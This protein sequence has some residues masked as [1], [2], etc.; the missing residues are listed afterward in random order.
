MDVEDLGQHPLH[1]WASGGGLPA[2]GRE[3]AHQAG[4]PHGCKRHGT[5]MLSSI[6]DTVK[7][8]VSKDTMK[9]PMN[10]T[11]LD[12]GYKGCLF[13]KGDNVPGTMEED[14]LWLIETHFEL[15]HPAPPLV[16]LEGSVDKVSWETFFWW[17]VHY[18][19]EI[20]CERG[21]VYAD[22]LFSSLDTNLGDVGDLIWDKLGERYFKMTEFELIVEADK[23]AVAETMQ[24][25]GQDQL[26][27]KQEKRII[28][29]RKGIAA[30][31]LTV[32]QQQGTKGIDTVEYQQQQDNQN[33]GRLQCCRAVGHR[34]QAGAACC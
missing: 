10:N 28:K 9:V 19:D 34:G 6:K 27:R 32:E 33:S 25:P 3:D 31:K 16:I 21:K 12:C 5:V 7:I 2:V 13:R 24:H 8:P 30:N 14:H 15:E 4:E 23:I 17:Y 1:V 18:R 11:T 26:V 29:D 22:K 20:L